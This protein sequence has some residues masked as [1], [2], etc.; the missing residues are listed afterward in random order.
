MWRRVLRP[1][2]RAVR[3]IRTPAE[4]QPTRE[5]A[6]FDRVRTRTGS[7]GEVT[8]VF[9]VAVVSQ[10]APRTPSVR[11]T[12]DVLGARELTTMDQATFAGQLETAGSTV[13]LCAEDV[14]LPFEGTLKERGPHARFTTEAGGVADAAA[15]RGIDTPVSRR[16][17]NPHLAKT[18]STY[19]LCTRHESSYRGTAVSSSRSVRE[20]TAVAPE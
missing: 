16:A 9:T 19:R 11:A 20:T 5:P 15:A 13:Q 8:V 2:S 18:C 10:T 7:P 4:P 6:P 17:D 14:M 3:T 12:H 1:E